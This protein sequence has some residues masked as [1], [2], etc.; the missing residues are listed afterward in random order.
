M[1]SNRFSLRAKNNSKLDYNKVIQSTLRI[2]TKR[3][4]EGK[5]ESERERIKMKTHRPRGEEGKEGMEGEAF[6]LKRS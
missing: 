1:T 4:R 2:I 6:G 5:R 3:R